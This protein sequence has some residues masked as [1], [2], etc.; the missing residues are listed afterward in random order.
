MK[1]WTGSQASIFKAIAA[2]NHTDAHRATDDFYATHPSAID[3]LLDYPHLT[4]VSVASRPW[5]AS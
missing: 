5:L 3:A 1:D 4:R 2:T